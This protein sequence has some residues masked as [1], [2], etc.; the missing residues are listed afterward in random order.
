MKERMSQK[1]IARRLGVSAMLVS[2]MATGK[3]PVSRQIASKLQEI[4]R[5]A[6]N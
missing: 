6:G 5:S 2:Y 3:R 4:N 1:E